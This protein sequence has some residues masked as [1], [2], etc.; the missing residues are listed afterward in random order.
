MRDRRLMIPSFQ[1]DG[2][3]PPGDY[4]KA[5]ATGWPDRA[6]LLRSAQGRAAYRAAAGGPIASSA[7]R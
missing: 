4:E 6:H 5:P 2:L 1:A 3:L 7:L